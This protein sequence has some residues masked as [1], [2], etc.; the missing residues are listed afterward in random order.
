MLA[1]NV[2]EIP[3]F[4]L[5]KTFAGSS[6]SPTLS[7]GVA[8]PSPAI[9]TH[10]AV[11]STVSDSLYNTPLGI[12]TLGAVSSSSTVNAG[13]LDSLKSTVLIVGLVTVIS[14][15]LVRG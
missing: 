1:S 14:I 6:V 4:V 7:T 10:F 13:M 2:T 15:V 8:V 5:G 9:V 11:S 12:V 3:Y